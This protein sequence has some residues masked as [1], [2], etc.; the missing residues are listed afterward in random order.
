MKKI[1]EEFKKFIMRGNVIDLAV[2]VVM[3]N[4][5]SKI[6]SS[7]VNDI[8]MPIIGIIIGGHDFSNLSITV[9]TAKIMYGAFIQNIINFL[10]IATSIFIFIKVINALTHKKEEIKEKEAKKEEVKASEEILL[11]REIRDSLQNKALRKTNP[12][13]FIIYLKT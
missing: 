11:L 6:V 9:G 10:I 13:A 8:M 3:G 7:L 4:A 1:I 2:G 5:F 12:S